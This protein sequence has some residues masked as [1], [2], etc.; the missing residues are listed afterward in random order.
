[1]A[2]LSLLKLVKNDQKCGSEFGDLL[3]RHLTPQI[4]TALYVHNYNPLVHKG[5]KVVLENLLPL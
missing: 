2:T 5:A 4:K 3:W 1:L